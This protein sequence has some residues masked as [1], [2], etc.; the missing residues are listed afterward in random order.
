MYIRHRNK[1]WREGRR[2]GGRTVGRNITQ[3]FLDFA[4]DLLFLHPWAQDCRELNSPGRSPT[5]PGKTRCRLVCQNIFV[6]GSRTIFKN[7]NKTNRAREETIASGRS[8]LSTWEGILKP[9][10]RSYAYRCLKETSESLTTSSV[11]AGGGRAV[12]TKELSS[13]FPAR[14]EFTLTAPGDWVW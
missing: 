12:V 5:V 11:K 14:V 10:L 4:E 3:I 8:E 7:N 6:H 9:S 1:Q 13:V 2:V